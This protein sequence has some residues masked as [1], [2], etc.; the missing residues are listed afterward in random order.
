M[1]YLSVFIYFLIY[2]SE[3]NYLI[4]IL[5]NFLILFSYFF[6]YCSSFLY[7]YIFFELSLVPILLMVLGFGSQ[8][9]K[10]NSCYYL[11]FYSIITSFPFIYVFF[12]F[13]SFF[14][15][16]YLDYFL[17]WE[18]LFF[19]SLRFFIKIPLYFLH[20]WLPKVHVEAP[21]SCSILLA[22][23]LLKFGGLGFLRLFG[24]FIYLNFFFWFLISVFGLLIGSFICMFQSDSK[25]LS[26]YSSVVHINF[27]VFSFFLFSCYSK[28][29]GLIIIVSHGYISSLIFFFIGEFYHSFFN[30]LLYFIKG[31]F[32]SN[33]FFSFFFSLL[34]L[35]NSGLPFGLSFF[36]EFLGV[37]SLLIIYFYI[38]FFLFLY[39]FFSFYYSVYFIVNFLMGKFYLGF[40]LFF[41]YYVIPFFFMVFNIFWFFFFWLIILIKILYFLYKDTFSFFFLHD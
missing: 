7:F 12:S 26:A 32:L 33:I 24:S 11:L 1:V 2:F 3:S 41:C 29:G 36:S 17:S 23:L 38:F 21:T 8:I 9:E 10:I 4:L 25:S 27:I 40:S 28:N 5:T 22:G 14:S 16:V 19:L 31:F 30:R 39:F 35:L 18:F 37:S 20:Y 34:I 15:F 6:F 13:Y